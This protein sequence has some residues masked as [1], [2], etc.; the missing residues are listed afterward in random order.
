M[1][2]AYFH[3]QVQ[4]LSDDVADNADRLGVLENIGLVVG[5][6]LLAHLIVEI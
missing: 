2:R 4:F 5:I 6:S 3:V 1:E